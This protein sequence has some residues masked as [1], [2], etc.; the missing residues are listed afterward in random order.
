MQKYRTSF[1]ELANSNGGVPRPNSFCKLLFSVLSRPINPI[2]TG[3]E[4]VY[5]LCRLQRVMVELGVTGPV[6][7]FKLEK[8]EAMIDQYIEIFTKSGFV[9][10]VFSQV[11][12]YIFTQFFSKI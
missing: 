3:G 4:V 5:L 6:K 1:I 11:L 9:I 7:L 12:V 10:F 2:L 8:L